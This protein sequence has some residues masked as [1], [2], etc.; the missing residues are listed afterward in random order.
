MFRIRTARPLRRVLVAG[1]V[2]VALTVVAGAVYQHVSDRLDAS[3]TP[4]GRLIDIGGY[5]LH[6]W[7][8]GTGMPAAV[9]D[10]GLGDHSFVWNFVLDGVSRFTTAC[11][12]DR[13]GEGYSDTGPSP[14]TTSQIASELATLLDR[15]DFR[16]PVIVVGASWGGFTARLFASRFPERTA[17][18][19]L[20]D[21]AHEDQG[22]DMPPFA[23][24]VPVAGSLGV[25]RLA[26]ITLGRDAD[27]EPDAVRPYQRATLFRA[28]RYRTLYDEVNHMTE[29]AEQMR[30]SRVR[31]SMPV[32]VVT[33]G[34]GN[35]DSH[36]RALQDNQAIISSRGCR[37]VAEGAGHL[38]HRDAPEIVVDAVRRVIQ[39]RS[40]P[41][42]D[43]C[44]LPARPD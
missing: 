38:V 33:S 29:S 20:V 31:L 16:E 24:L 15:G 35:N 2:L 40:N 12:Y 28:A 18:V 43:P 4:P 27:T 42:S 5:R 32:V 23:P 36:W 39:A 3:T 1:V 9:F 30:N 44:S 13:S 14:R 11:A 25:L 26:R 37:I 41:V 21:A 34:R 6:M 22:F 17:G 19:V 8:K 10:A 7:C